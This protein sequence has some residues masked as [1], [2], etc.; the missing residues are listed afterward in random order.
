MRA[1]RI[2]SL[3]GLFSATA[4]LAQGPSAKRPLTQADWD[5]WRSITGASLSPDGRWAAYTLIPQVGDGELVVRSTRDTTEYRVPRGFLGR[6]NNVPGGL[7]PP[8]GANPE[9]EPAGPNASPA[10]FSADSRFVVVI[11]QPS[12]RELEQQ[13]RAR[14]AG[15]RGRGA[16]GA[17]ASQTRNSLAILNLA[18][19]SVAS[20]PN[21]RSFRLPRNGTWLAYLAEPDSTADTT[22]AGQGGGRPPQAA[23]GSS[24]PRRT[25]GS[26]LMLRNLSTGVAERFN[27][28]LTY[29]FDDS[30]KALA[31]TVVSRDSTRDGAFYRSLRSGTTVTLATGRGDYKAIALDRSGT[32]VTFLSNRA[33]FGKEKPRFSVYHAVI[34]NTSSRRGAAGPAVQG[35]AGIAVTP[36]VLAEGTRINDNAGVSFTRAGNAILVGLS[37]ILPDSVPADSLVGKAVFDLWHWKDPALQPAQRLSAARDRNRSFQAIYFPG[38]RKLVPLASDSI[39]TVDIADDAKSGLATSRERYRIESMWGDGGLDVYALDPT[40][41][42]LRL[43]RE[44]ISGSAQLSPDGRYITFF[45]RGR[46]YAHNTRTGKTADLT[47]GLTGVSFEQETWDTPSIPGAWGVAGWTTGDKSVLIYDRWDVWELDPEGKRPPVM[48]TDSLGRTEH[49]VLRVMQTRRSRGGGSGGGGGGGGGPFG[50]GGTTEP[51]DPAEPLLIRA[52]DDETRAT[53]FYRDRLGVRAAPERIV[54]AEA[55][56]GIPQKAEDAGQ[57]LV[58]RGTFTEFPDLWTG[59]SLASLTRISEA[60]PQQREYR[61]GTVELVRWT[62]ADGVPLKGLLYKPENFD[63]TRQ[64]PMIAYFYEQLSQNLHSYV[65]PN[66]RNVINPTH[67]VSNGYLIFEPDIHYQEGYPGASALKSIVPGVQALLARGFVDPKRL[68]LQG[69]SWGGYQTAYLITRTNM[70]TAAMAGAPVVN[71]TSAYGGIRWGSGLARSFQYET[72]QSRIGGSLWETPMRYFENSPLFWL[73][74]VTTPLLM[75]HNDMDD[76]VPWYQGIEFFV[77]MRRLGKEVYLLNYNNDVHNP[78]SRANQKDIA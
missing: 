78:A 56:F 60:N 49:V 55:A 26:P 3:L 21:V 48:V 72:G 24:A 20:I 54:M 63:S 13:E 37:P 66:G 70:F 4:V 28:V 51:F 32:L 67:Y 33:E 5:R 9:A 74:R 61:W 76:A 38:S 15:Q 42:T 65:P 64:Y 69:Q 16:G 23:G 25:Y 71:M 40:S 2:I 31:Y 8:A 17:G 14:G 35:A 22:R 30:A 7:R 10:Q 53:G 12:Q 77:A 39:P 75:M 18:D 50:G 19:G 47:G 73:D 29:T 68:G 41:G 11:V 6:P 45:D 52:V 58:T 59:S 27:D 57:W 62:S 43:I 36:A 34:K 1:I 46:W 44:K